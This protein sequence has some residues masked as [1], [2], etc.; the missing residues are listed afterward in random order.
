MTKEPKLAMATRIVKE[1]ADYDNDIKELLKTHQPKTAQESKAK[2][3]KDE[4]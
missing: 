3:K 2:P 1:W 4:L